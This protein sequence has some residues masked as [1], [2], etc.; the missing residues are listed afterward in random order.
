[1]TFKLKKPQ[2]SLRVDCQGGVIY[3]NSTLG[4]HQH[5]F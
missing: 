3:P 2:Q 5:T 4:A 1:L